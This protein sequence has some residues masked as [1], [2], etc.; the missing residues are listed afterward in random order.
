[1]RS[2]LRIRPPG[3]FACGPPPAPV[4]AGAVGARCRALCAG[5]G[6]CVGAL[7]CCVGAGAAGALVAS[8]VD[9]A[10]AEAGS[11]RAN[12]PAV[13]VAGAF[14]S[15]FRIANSA[16]PVPAVVGLNNEFTVCGSLD[17]VAAGRG[18]PVVVGAI[19]VSIM[20]KLYNA[21]S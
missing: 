13:L 20:Q 17:A 2:I 15:G 9:I 16:L 18:D 4:E 5:A 7:F 3:F 8:A 14:V 11:L 12:A 19:I 21:I 10:G 6:C 1:L